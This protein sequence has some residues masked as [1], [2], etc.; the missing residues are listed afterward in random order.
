MANRG[1]GKSTLTVLL[2]ISAQQTYPTERILIVDA[3]QALNLE[4]AE[5]LGLNTS[6]DNL[7]I[8]QPQSANEALGIYVKAI[9]SGLFSLVILDSIPALIPERDLD[10]EVGDRQV[11]T[12]ASLLSSEVRK[13]VNLAKKTNTAALMIN[14]IRAG[15]GFMVAEKVIPGGNAMKFYP[16]VNI[17]LKRTDLIKKGD[18]YIGQTVRANFVKNRFATPYKKADYDLYYGE[19]IRKSNEA[20]EVAKDLG[21]IQGKGWYTYPIA[22]GETERLQGIENVI[23]WYK[24]NPVAFEYL[25][26]LVI[27]SFK[28][29][30]VVETPEEEELEDDSEI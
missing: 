12:L 11:A 29:T 5:E 22:E 30:K 3:E 24:E 28:K 8:I 26:G 9:E 23:N 17:E 10:A 16:S 4:Y 15:I 27:N 6:E 19:G 2:A 18:G 1:C 14:Q 21:I 20:V 25:E 13:V 7:T